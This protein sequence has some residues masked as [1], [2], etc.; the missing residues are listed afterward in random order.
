MMVD[1]EALLDD[2]FSVAD[3]LVKLARGNDGELALLAGDA[4]AALT[5]LV[6]RLSHLPEPTGNPAQE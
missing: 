2:C 1:Q 4:L 6:D 3:R 5:P